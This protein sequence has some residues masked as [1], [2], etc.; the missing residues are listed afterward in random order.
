MIHLVLGGA[1]SGKTRFGMQAAKMCSDKGFQCVYIATAQ[2]L[3]DEMSDRIKRHQQERDAD[4]VNWLTTETPLELVTA[5]REFAREDRVIM[6]DC[7]TLWLTNHLLLD[8][9]STVFADPEHRW[10]KEKQ[11]LLDILPQLPGEIY[12]ISNEVGCGIVPL[13]EISRRF[14]DEAGWLHQDIAAIA[15]TVTLVTAGIPMRLK[16]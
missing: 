1:R 8:D 2:P 14:V 15:D 13:G 12:L 6:V 3:D 9:S 11:Q 7:L 10:S 5:L 4:N 16:G